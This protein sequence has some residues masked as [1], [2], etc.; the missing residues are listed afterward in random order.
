ML[1][2][3]FLMV[4]IT[5][6]VSPAGRVVGVWLGRLSAGQ[7]QNVLRTLMTEPRGGWPC[8]WYAS[9]FPG[10]AQTQSD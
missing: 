9:S 10:L 3:R 2:S 1:A 4:P 5:L 8:P 6:A 7:V